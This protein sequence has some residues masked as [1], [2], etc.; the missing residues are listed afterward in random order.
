MWHDQNTQS[1]SEKKKYSDCNI[2]A[3]ASLGEIKSHS[4]RAKHFWKYFS[5]LKVLSMYLT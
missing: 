2:F 5:E 4:L 3:M 1:P